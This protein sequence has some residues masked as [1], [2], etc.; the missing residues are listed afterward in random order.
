[1]MP[2]SFPPSRHDLDNEF[3]AKKIFQT[4]QPFYFAFNLYR[5]KAY[6]KANPGGHAFGRGGPYKHGG[7]LSQGRTSAYLIKSIDKS[8]LLEVIRNIGL[9]IST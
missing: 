8:L 9:N 4:S 1:M 3:R 2:A 6:P 7:R 5:I